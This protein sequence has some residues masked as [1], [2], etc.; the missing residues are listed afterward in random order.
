MI[1]KTNKNFKKEKEFD[2]RIVDLARVTRVMAGGKRM[3]FRATVVIGDKQTKVAVGVGKGADVTVAINKAVNRAKKQFVMTPSIEGTIPCEI[4]VKNG[5]AVIFLKPAK[6]GTG[7]IAGSAVRTVLE[8]SGLK[9]V[10][11]KIYG[12]KNK[13][14]N[15]R[16]T[17]TAL[18]LL[19][20]MV[21]KRQNLLDIKKK[22]AKP[23]VKK[24]ETKKAEVKKVEV[25]KAEVKKEISKKAPVAKAVKK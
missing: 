6:P 23:E 24:A 1:K 10:V 3:N 17:L 14:N 12:S 4:K 8:L 18:E 11:G 7:I 16:A 25:K 22:N 5:A 19:G 20:K 21:G 2:Q 15:V 9:D 13:I